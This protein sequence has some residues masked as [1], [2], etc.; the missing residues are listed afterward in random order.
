MAQSHMKK[1]IFI[2]SILFLSCIISFI[3]EPY[4]DPIWK[5]AIS[6][7]RLIDTDTLQLVWVKDDVYIDA[8]QRVN[9]LQANDDTVVFFGNNSRF[10]D[11]VIAALDSET[12]EIKW[13][14]PGGNVLSGE[15]NSIGINQNYIFVG[16][17]GTGKPIEQS[18]VG[19][20][21]VIAYH[22]AS[23]EVAWT[24]VIP[25]ARQINSIA[26]SNRFLSVDGG[27][28]KYTRLNANTGEIL[29]TVNKGE[30]WD[31]NFFLSTTNYGV[32]FDFL[33]EKDGLNVGDLRHW[34]MTFKQ[35]NVHNPPIRQS[36]I[37][38]YQST[39][40]DSVLLKGV[41]EETGNVLWGDDFNAVGN[42]AANETYVYLLTRDARLL[43]I[44]IINGQIKGFAQFQPKELNLSPE[45]SS[46]VAASGNIVIVYFGES[47]RL[48]ALRVNNQ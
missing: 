3:I 18:L 42:V 40:P 41:N 23:G 1:R 12:G 47:R 2:V 31:D 16:I 34:A 15:T 4:L 11:A 27:G 39:M 46:Y 8:N 20:G 22:T 26:V 25:G 7:H 44:D 14:R 6:D 9:F 5:K 33:S 43:V 21:R 19:A 35:E 37:V 48:I 28:A 45:Y 17:D 32:L 29:G 13:Y 38:V 36:R 30:N 24:R 10:K